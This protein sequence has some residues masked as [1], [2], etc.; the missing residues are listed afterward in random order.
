MHRESYIVRDV[1]SEIPPTACA[2]ACSSARRALGCCACRCRWATPSSDRCSS[3]RAETDQFSE[4]DILF[5]RRVADHLALA[6]SHQRLSEAAAPRRRPRAKTAARLEAQV[7]TL[8][9]ELERARGA[10]VSIGQ[11][12]AWKDVLAHAAR[13]A[14]TETTV[15][16]TGESGTGKEVVAR[17][18]HP[19]SRRSNGPFVAINCAAL[20]DHCSSRSSSA[21]SAAPLPA[22]VAAKPGRWNRPA[23]ASS[24][25]TKSARWRH[26]CKPSC[27]ACSRNASSSAREHARAACRHPR[28]RRDEP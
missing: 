13:V 5:A 24:F 3:S 6:L 17:F 1:E 28:H 12:P 20:P 7:A 19:R 23:A 27:C 22:P 10:A 26:R 14:Q 15:L 2:G 25:S 9:R 18:I 11:S 4:E 21:T 8:T 16:L